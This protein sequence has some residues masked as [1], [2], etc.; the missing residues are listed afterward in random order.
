MTL[1]P[2]HVQPCGAVVVAIAMAALG[3]PVA[4]TAAPVAAA[5]QAPGLAL[6]DSIGVL[7]YLGERS[8]TDARPGHSY[9]YRAAGLA[10]DVSVS[11]YGTQ[12]LPDGI[13]SSLFRAQ[14]ARAERAA[15]ASAPARLLEEGTVTLGTDASVPAREAVLALGGP[16]RESTSYLWMAARA[17]DLYAI[18][19]DVHAGFED[20]G[21]VSRSEALAALGDAIE[22]P[23]I[24]D[25]SSAPQL[26]VVMQWDPKTPPSER[27]LWTMYLY[28][29]AAAAAVA[30]E[31]ERLPVGEH[32]A[33]FDEEF[34]A[35]LL[36]LSLY[37]QLRRSQPAPASR[38]FE[39]LDRIATA[40]YLREYVWRYLRS[41]S[42]TRAPDGLALARFDAWRATHLRHHVPVTHGRIAL[43]LAAR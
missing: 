3:N 16:T 26:D 1:R 41:A 30:M 42:W 10:L 33:S 22:H 13:T 36:A 9:S 29:R 15:L 12:S 34:R 37:R 19:L 14:F 35:R 31:H 18:R 23:G 25:A 24:T 8:R 39:D 2:R 7:D 21:H 5:S 20:D 17:G 6:P 43:R 4:A 40:G 11:R 38:Y 32:A 28:T 27:E